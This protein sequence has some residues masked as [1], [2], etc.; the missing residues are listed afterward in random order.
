MGISKAHLNYL[1]RGDRRLTWKVARR[2]GELTDK[3]ARDWLAMQADAD[4]AEGKGQAD[5]DLAA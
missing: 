2:L 3:S 1:I 4:L 5:H